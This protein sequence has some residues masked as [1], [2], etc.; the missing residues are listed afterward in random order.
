MG[1]K[2]ASAVKRRVG[3]WAWEEDTADG[4]GG[5]RR[6]GQ[7]KGADAAEEMCLWMDFLVMTAIVVRP[8]KRV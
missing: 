5:Q 1:E 3:E 8:S 4:V 6:A 2:V 7:G